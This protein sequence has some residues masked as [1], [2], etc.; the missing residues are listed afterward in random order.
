MSIGPASQKLKTNLIFGRF[1]QC[2]Y[3]VAAG[4]GFWS[5][6]LRK[7]FLATLTYPYAWLRRRLLITI[8]QLNLGTQILSMRALMLAREQGQVTSTQAEIRSQQSNPKK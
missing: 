6:M 1:P 5:L 8:R 4:I 7:I 2:N 3:N